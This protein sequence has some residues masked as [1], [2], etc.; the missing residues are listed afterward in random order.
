MMVLYSPF[1]VEK[2]TRVLKEQVDPM[3]GIFRCLITLNAARFVGTSVV[4]GKI[5]K[6]YFELRNRND[7][8][9]SLRLIGEL[10]KG[11]AGSIISISWVKPP[12]FDFIAVV[13]LKRYDNDRSIILKFLEEWLH[14]RPME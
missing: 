3:P 1:S 4:C 5:R 13:L 14:T 11:E 8:Y 9:L 7:P 2:A 12:F 10:K 6:N